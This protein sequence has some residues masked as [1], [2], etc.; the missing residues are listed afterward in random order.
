LGGGG[1]S[2][3][4]GGRQWHALYNKRVGGAGG[5]G[6]AIKFISSEIS[7]ERKGQGTADEKLPT[8]LDKGERGGNIENSFK[9]PVRATRE[10]RKW[11]NS[12]RKRG[13][14]FQF[15]GIHNSA[16]VETGVMT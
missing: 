7:R 16:G 15:R 13:F 3:Q 4:G 5:G 1:S 12:E 8:M 6:G 14:V 10:G 9:K 2:A 11:W